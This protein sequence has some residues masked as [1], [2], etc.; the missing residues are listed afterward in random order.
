MAS[1]RR[2]AGREGDPATREQL[3]ALAARAGHGLAE[4]ANDIRNAI[5]A[6][7]PALREGGRHPSLLETSIRQNVDA[8]L[9]ILAHRIDPKAVNAPS[10][11]VEYARTLAQRGVSMLTLVRAYRIGQREFLS[12][13]IADLVRHNAGDKG[14]GRATLELVENVSDYVDRVVEQVLVEYA[15]AR[16]EWLS[17]NGILAARVQS[18]LYD[19]DIGVE[20]AEARLGRRLRQHFLAVEAWQRPSGARAAWPEVT[21]S[22][23]AAAGCAEPPVTVLVDA[24]SACLWLPLGKQDDVDMPKIGRAVAGLPG[25]YAA[26]GEV[27]PSLAGFRRSHRQASSAK[28]VAQVSAPPRERLT[29]YADVAPIAAMTSDLD[30]TRAWVDETLGALAADDERHAA[31]RE[32]LRVFL[33]SGSSY[34]ATAQRLRVH[35][36]TAQYRIRKAEE[37]RGKPLRSGRLDLELALLAAHWFGRRVLR[38]P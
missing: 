21:T 26:A 27:G 2:P 15:K 13:V 16:E 34:A 17:P 22:L 11:A 4:L 29:P 37:L 28:A 10:G 1:K 25:T 9:G 20:A 8:E 12:R 14:E 5:E 30:S 32:T 18:I 33:E 23:A 6:D 31:L 36:N 3:E 7:V 35:R 38:H 19:E 24:Y